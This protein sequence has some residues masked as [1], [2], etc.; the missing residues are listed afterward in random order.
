MT[1]SFDRLVWAGSIRD[2][3]SRGLPDAERRL[4]DGVKAL[5]DE[6]SVVCV[7]VCVCV[8]VCEHL[9]GHAEALVDVVGAVEV[10]VVDHPLPPHRRPR[11]C[12][13]TRAR[14]RAHTH[15]HTQTGR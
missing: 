6:Y 9:A 3:L 11:L 5:V 1:S 8:R 2:Y 10:R 12:T 13:H 4:A 15:T 7:C 14:A